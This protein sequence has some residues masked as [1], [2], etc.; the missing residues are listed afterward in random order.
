MRTNSAHD[1]GAAGLVACTDV[2]VVLRPGIADVAMSL[3]RWVLTVAG[4]AV[5]LWAGSVVMATPAS[6]AVVVPMAASVNTAKG[7]KEN[8]SGGGEKKSSGDKKSSGEKAS[9]GDKK[10]SDKGSGDKKSNEKKSS[11]KKSGEKKSAEKKSA[12]KKSNDKDAGDKKSKAK[13]Q[14][15]ERTTPKDKATRPATQTATTAKDKGADKRK[16]EDKASAAKD[17]AKSTA[18]ELK[19]KANAAAAEAKAKVQAAIAKA[20]DKADDKTDATERPHTW[21]GRNP[22]AD[23]TVANVVQDATKIAASLR[24]TTGKKRA[25]LLKQATR[26]VEQVGAEIVKDPKVTA[27]LDKAGVQHG[28]GVTEKPH[29]W[30][31]RNPKAVATAVQDATKIAASLRGTTGKKRADLL[32]QATRWVEQVGAEIVKDP[33]VTAVL[34]K[35][36]VQHGI[37]VTEKPHTWIGR[38]PKAVATAVQDATKIAASLRGTTGKK[39]ADLLK[40]ATRWVEQVGAEIVKDPKVAA[41]LDKAGVHHGLDATALPHTMEGHRC[42]DGSFGGKE[43]AGTTTGEQGRP[44]GRGPPSD[45]KASDEENPVENVLEGRIAV[46]RGKDALVKE[47]RNVAAGKGNAKTYAQHVKAQQ[48]LEKRVAADSAQLSTHQNKLVNDVVAGHRTITASDATLV[49]EQKLVATGK[50]SAATYRAHVAA[51]ATRKAKVYAATDELQ[52]LIDRSNDEARAPPLDEDGAAAGCGRSGAIVEC[53]TASKVGKTDTTN[54]CLALA[55]ISTG[56]SAAS[57]SGTVKAAASCTLAGSNQGCRSTATHGATTASSSCTGTADCAHRSTATATEASTTCRTAGGTCQGSTSGPRTSTKVAANTTTASCTGACDL[58]G[59]ADARN[60]DTD[61]RT[62]NGTCSARGVGRGVSGGTASCRIAG[63]TCEA[64]GG[65]RYVNGVLSSTAD[66]T[67]D[68]RAVTC[69]GVTETAARGAVRGVAAAGKAIPVRATTTTSRCSIKA[70]DCTSQAGSDVTTVAG[71]VAGTRDGVA[72]STGGSDV[73]CETTTCTAGITGATSGAATGDVKRGSG[74][75]VGCTVHGDG[76][77]CETDSDSK[78]TA[79][80]GSNVDAQLGCT[81]AVGTC[82]G[83]TT[84]ATS[85]RDTAVTP[86]LRGTSTT[87]TCTVTGGDCTGRSVSAASSAPDY[88]VLDPATGKPTAGQALTGPS[89]IARSDAALECAAA[90][91]SG[92]VTTKTTAYDGRTATA[93]VPRSSA[94]S[95]SCSGGTGGCQA[96]SVSTAATGPGAALALAGPGQ[97]TNPAR[98]AAGPSAASTSGAVLPCQGAS[99][100]TGRVTSAASATDPKVSLSPRGSSSNGSCTGV[101]SGICQAVTNSGASSGPDANRI[102]PIMKATSTKNATVTSESTGD[103]SQDQQNGTPGQ[104]QPATPPAPTAPG[105]SANTG[106]PT[107]PGA[108]S[109]SMADATLD[110]A[111][112]TGCTGTVRSSATGTDG[113][114]AASGV[115]GARGPPAGSSTSTGTCTATQSACQA[116]TSSTAA[117]GQV[118]AD[119]IAAQRKDDAEQLAQQAAKASEVAEQAKQVAAR[120][121]ATAQ[122]IKKAKDAATAATAARKAA[123][124]AAALAKKPVTDAPATHSTSSAGAQCAGTGCTARTTGSAPGP[125]GAPQSAATCVAGASG[126][127][128][129]SQA[130][131]STKRVSAGRA[132]TGVAGNGSA[133]SQVVCPEVGCTGTVTGRT[134]AVVDSAGRRVT[135]AGTGTSGCTGAKACVA[136]VTVGAT[137]SALPVRRGIPTV[138]IGAWV[139]A[140]CDDGTATGCATRTVATG[141]ARAPGATASSTATCAAAGSCTAAVGAAV[142]GSIARVAAE[143]AGTGCRARTRGVG[144][145]RAVGG[146]HTA[147]FSTDCIAGRAGRCSSGGSVAATIDYALAGAECSGSKGA[148]C[149]FGFRAQGRA[150]APGSTAGATVTGGGTTGSGTGLAAVAAARGVASAAAEC[151]GSAAAVCRS[152]AVFVAAAAA[153][154]KSRARAA[155]S[156]VGTGVRRGSVAVSAQAGAGRGWALA[157]ASCKGT[158][159]CAHSYAASAKDAAKAGGSRARAAAAGSGGGRAGRGTVAVTAQAAAGRGWAMARASCAGAANCRHSYAARAADRAAF[160]G[161][162]ARASASGSGAGGRGHGQVAV[163]AQAAAGPGYRVRLG[164]V[165]RRGQLPLL[166]RGARF[167]RCLLRR[168]RAPLVGARLGLRQRRGPGRRRRTVGAGAGAG[169]PRLRVRERG[170][171]RCGELPGLVL[172]PRRGLEDGREPARPGVVDVPGRRRG[173]FL[174]LAGHGRGHRVHGVRAGRLLGHRKVLLRLLDAVDLLGHRAGHEGEQRR[175]LPRR[176]LRL[177]R[178]RIEGHVQ[179]EDRE[180]RAELVLR[181]VGWVLQALGHHRRRRGIAG[182]AALRQGTAPLRRQ[183]GLLL[184]RRGGQVPPGRIRQGQVRAAAARRRGQLHQQ[185]QGFLLAPAGGQRQR[186]RPRRR[187]H[188]QGQDQLLRFFGLVHARH[189]G[190]VHDEARAGRLRQL[191]RQGRQQVRPDRGAHRRPAHQARSP[192]A[193]RAGAGVRQRQRPR[194]LHPAHRRRLLGLRQ[195]HLPRRPPGV[196][197]RQER[198]ARP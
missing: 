150:K 98:L 42:A 92:T 26:W 23:R 86:N 45:E 130:S 2:C 9:G 70:G 144:K 20:K 148:R 16:A 81:G 146:W 161:N 190:G 149:A 77:T 6:A 39:R 46:Q 135:A 61:C 89:S 186:P 108:S 90:R 168:R 101:A 133:G 181:D 126:C 21:I 131:S 1:S 7:G 53:T 78:V 105:S 91:C 125:W 80:S 37:G 178:H 162:R 189:G 41:V 167:V 197:V 87:A 18:A 97:A 141:T 116:R 85:A 134:S 171:Q 193:R 33:K 194:R 115:N 120:T 3:V 60:A 55:G 62:E 192:R 138:N 169:R 145:A 155:A 104:D 69:N 17:K 56:C 38:N 142:Q 40:Q 117:T 43:C 96:R 88:V 182:Q 157:G 173:R 74:G 174:R 28:I 51:Q 82:G 152:S 10:S 58:D 83:T 59:R 121:G 57:G 30:I 52:G 191:R 175:G 154:G 139:S 68:C 147:S 180:A 114:R 36:G 95:A 106:G 177:L 24:G 71:A 158:A 12:D 75:T 65:S 156:A 44:E 19:A 22:K 113:T 123:R 8:S 11:D 129:A 196:R 64:T 137:Y 102:A 163:S 5:A 49:A 165:R 143:C 170:L 198:Q 176:W 127:V 188:G 66:A 160:G 34:D 159:R 47:K 32:K 195:V 122:D 76:G 109:W 93:T 13:P 151:S 187:H 14:P 79:Q 166:L 124:D 119:V 172:Q 111:S 140:A 128:A 4:L 25:D 110:C 94:G 118:V 73:D 132:G 112:N 99:T 185:G 63:G 72:N 31:G 50:M 100:C 15:A 184:A 183:H 164:V 27:V 48:E 179:Q 67:V 29:T 35:A 107:V 54:R 136:Q 153:R 84:A 103:D